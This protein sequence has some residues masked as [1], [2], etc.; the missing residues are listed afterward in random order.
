LLAAGVA[1]VTGVQGSTVAVAANDDEGRTGGGG[2]GGRGGG[3]EWIFMEGP[4]HASI[5]H[6][7]GIGAALRLIQAR[8]VPEKLAAIL[9]V[10]A[11]SR[12]RRPTRLAD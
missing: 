7:V 5:E 9:S 12:C 1:E 3:S 2:G 10:S 4:G 11:M 8:T 6:P